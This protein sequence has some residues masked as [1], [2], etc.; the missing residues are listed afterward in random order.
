[1]KKKN[2]KQNEPNKHT[3][4]EKNIAAAEKKCQIS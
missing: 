2:N 1:M 4:K 3:R